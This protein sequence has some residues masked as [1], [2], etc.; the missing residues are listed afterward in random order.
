MKYKYNCMMYNKLLV[1]I[2][3]ILKIMKPIIKL[4]DLVYPKSLPRKTSNI[5][6]RIIRMDSQTIRVLYILI[7]S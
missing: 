4:H 6:V 2:I 5:T 7:D 1:L 3:N